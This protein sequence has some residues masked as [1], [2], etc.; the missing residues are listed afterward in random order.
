MLFVLILNSNSHTSNQKEK[1][2]V[3]SHWSSVKDQNSENIENFAFNRFILTLMAFS[4][5]FQHSEKYWNTGIYPDSLKNIKQLMANT[6]I[7]YP[8]YYAKCR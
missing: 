2:L 8:T 5:W 1:V 6:D 4:K 7:W 3:S